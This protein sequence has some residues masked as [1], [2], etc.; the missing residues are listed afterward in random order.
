MEL[1]DISYLAELTSSHPLLICL[2]RSANQSA[3]GFL[4][5]P[6]LRDK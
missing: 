3:G 4:F 2:S 6:Q 1:S 5:V